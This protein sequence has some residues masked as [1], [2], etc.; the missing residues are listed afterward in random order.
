MELGLPPKA[1]DT[2]LVVVKAPG[3]VVPPGTVKAKKAAAPFGLGAYTK[4]GAK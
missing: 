4:G 3:L 1:K 2:G